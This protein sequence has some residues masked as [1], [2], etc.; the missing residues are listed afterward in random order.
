[1]WAMPQLGVGPATWRNIPHGIC[2]FCRIGLRQILGPSPCGP[3]LQD[4]SG[5]QSL[6][7]VIPP[8]LVMEC[9]KLKGWHVKQY[10]SI[11]SFKTDHFFIPFSL[12]WWSRGGHTMNRPNDLPKLSKM[13]TAGPWRFPFVPN[14]YIHTPIGFVTTQQQILT[15][16]G[17]F[18]KWGIPN[19]SWMI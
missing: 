11:G 13:T 18:H 10:A 4:C 2:C 7:G 3:G 15:Q 6:H 17:G 9:P 14:L 1:M 16:Y 12:G 8:G 19:N 5:G